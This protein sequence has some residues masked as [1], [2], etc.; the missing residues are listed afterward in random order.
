M[1]TIAVL[2]LSAGLLTAEAPFAC[3]LKAF[4]PDERSQWRK[5]IEEVTSAVVTARELPDGY[6]LQI[7]PRRAS[8]VKIAEWAALERKCCPLFDFELKM[9][10][11]DGSVWLSLK[12][13]DGV[14]D[15]IREDFT[16]LR[17]KFSK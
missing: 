11:E 17:D 13:R 8:L 3:N 4:Q 6:A 7:D 14:K 5:L 16:L 1:K 2:L 12:G 10:G 9:H 15:F